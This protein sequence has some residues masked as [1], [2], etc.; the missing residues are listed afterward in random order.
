MHLIYVN[1][2]GS[3][4]KGQKQYEFIFSEDVEIDMSL[5]VHDQRVHGP[6]IVVEAGLGVRLDDIPFLLAQLGADLRQVRRVGKQ[7]KIL[8]IDGDHPD[9][10][11]LSV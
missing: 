2:I 6:R 1:E 11:L 4:Y 8:G 9:S 7:D 5:H 10:Q 3:D